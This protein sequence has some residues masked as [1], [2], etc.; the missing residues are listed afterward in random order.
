MV[1]EKKKKRKRKEKTVKRKLFKKERK[2]RKKKRLKFTTVPSLVSSRVALLSFIAATAQQQTTL[3]RI[4]DIIL[5]RIL[6]ATIGGGRMLTVN[7]LKREEQ[8]E[9]YEFWINEHSY[10][11][12][13][14]STGI[15]G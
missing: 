10:S 6:T 9:Y 4:I 2:N 5:Q 11:D 15:V 12:I 7:K 13:I 1:K 3:I 14:T 8:I